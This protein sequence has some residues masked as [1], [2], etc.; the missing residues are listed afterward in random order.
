MTV[1]ARNGYRLDVPEIDRSTAALPGQ[2]NRGSSKRENLDD[3]HRTLIA[4]AKAARNEAAEILKT[5]TVRD[6]SDGTIEKYTIVK[7]EGN[8]DIF[9]NEITDVS[10]FGSALLAAK[11]GI[12]RAWTPNGLRILH[13]L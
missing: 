11:N 7:G 12:A 8:G 2:H 9:N 4:K 10:P 1:Y 6:D 5:V 13:I 3:Y